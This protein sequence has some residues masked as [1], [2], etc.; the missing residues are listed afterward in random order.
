M[1]LGLFNSFLKWNNEIFLLW[2]LFTLLQLLYESFLFIFKVF[3][4]LFILLLQ[5]LF[6]FDYFLCTIRSRLFRSR[7]FLYFRLLSNFG[8]TYILYF[9]LF[10]RFF[11]EKI[12]IE[13]FLLSQNNFFYHRSQNSFSIWMHISY[14]YVLQRIEA[15]YISEILQTLVSISIVFWRG[16]LCYSWTSI[17]YISLND[18]SSKLRIEILDD[19]VECNIVAVIFLENMFFHFIYL[20]NIS[21]V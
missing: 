12:L 2:I 20:P 13:I 6:Q 11:L 1:Y 15:K 7:S 8:W 9:I 10:G 16:W 18:D 14:S 5:L 19:P 4:L 21:V 17:L 3:D